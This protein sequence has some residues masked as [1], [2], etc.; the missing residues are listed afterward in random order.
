MTTHLV[1]LCYLETSHPVTLEN[2]YAP[3]ADQCVISERRSYSSERESDGSVQSRLWYLKCYSSRETAILHLGSD[4]Q[5]STLL[6]L[7]TSVA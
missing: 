2:V 5:F 3:L 1:D 4:I 6:T 7:G